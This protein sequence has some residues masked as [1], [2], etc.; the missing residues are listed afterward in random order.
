MAAA[1]DDVVVQSGWCCM[2]S[3]FAEFNIIAVSWNHKKA[4]RVTVFSSI[5]I[6]KR[7]DCVVVVY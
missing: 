1:V 6:S 3:T 2:H 4:Y 5:K 7:D